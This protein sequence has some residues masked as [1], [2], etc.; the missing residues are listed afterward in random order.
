MVVDEPWFCPWELPFCPWEL[1]SSFAAWAAVAA[2]SGR[3]TARA[4]ATRHCRSD[5]ARMC[6]SFRIWAAAIGPVSL[7]A[8]G[9]GSD[10]R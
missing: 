8:A 5:R 1:P 6:T 2:V 7:G 3:V 9:R 10:V 4:A